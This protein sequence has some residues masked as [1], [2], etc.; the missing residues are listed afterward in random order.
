V[1]RATQK[2]QASLALKRERHSRA[3]ADR[4]TKAR[5]NTAR[6]IKEQQDKAR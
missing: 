3:A 5:A 4:V 6:A 1:S 2:L